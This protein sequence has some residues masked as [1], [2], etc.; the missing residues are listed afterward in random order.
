M[1]HNVEQQSA[2]WFDLRRDF[3][4]TASNAQA[5]G[6]N[7]KGL[8]SLIL[9]KLSEKF[10][11]AEAES[12]SD[13]HTE[14][15]NS[16]EPLARSAYESERLVEVRT[17][18]FIT[19]E[20]Y[21]LAGASPDGLVEDGGIEIKCFSDKKHFENILNFEIESKYLWQMQMQ[22]LICELNWVDFVIFNPNFQKSLLIQR[23]YPIAEYRIKIKDGLV[24][25]A[26]KY[27]A[28]MAKCKNII[29]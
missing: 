1:I 19:N 20:Q 12:F 7:E 25:G 5:I 2:E 28:L 17:V 8:D 11:T 4:L 27:L 24:D 6:N 23:V 9:K 29:N 18:G 15:G 3:P 21:P 13:E 10:S 16:L 26:K 22:M 14:R